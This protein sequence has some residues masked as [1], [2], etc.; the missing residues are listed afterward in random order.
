ML[1]GPGIPFSDPATD[2]TDPQASSGSVS[3]TSYYGRAATILLT[4]PSFK[5]SKIL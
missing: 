2:P 4:I 1:Y 5:S 3:M